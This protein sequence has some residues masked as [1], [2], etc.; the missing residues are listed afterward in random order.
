MH[1]GGVPP[2]F[3]STSCVMKTPGTRTCPRCTLG[4]LPISLYINWLTIHDCTSHRKTY[5]NVRPRRA[6]GD[7]RYEPIAKVESS[8]S[9]APA[10]LWTS[11]HHARRPTE[12]TLHDRCRQD[13]PRRRPHLPNGGDCRHRHGHLGADLPM[14]AVNGGASAHRRPPHAGTKRAGSDLIPF[15]KFDSNRTAEPVVSNR[16][17]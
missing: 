16:C 4:E 6:N 3:T 8:G 15:M 9:G 13:C 7:A 1:A 12:H 11:R 10:P 14:I 5:H 2:E 17:R